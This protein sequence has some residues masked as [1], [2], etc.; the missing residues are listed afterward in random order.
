ML[1]FTAQRVSEVV[2]ARWDEVDL[3]TATW[4]I[5]RMR[6][7]KKDAARG[8]HVVPLP[9]RLAAL[10]KQWRGEDDGAGNFVCPA[11][12]DPAKSITAE[13]C[14]KHYRDVLGLAGKHSPHSWRSS[15]STVC[16]EAGKN[17]DVIE[18]QLDHQVGNKTESAYD[19]ATRLDL[20]C[21][22]MTWYESALVAARDG[23][24]VVPLPSRRRRD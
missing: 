22:L 6:M 15:F 23:A 8:P 2:G 7:K 21:E 11:P 20:R 13:A 17:R 5:P 16:R 1:A 12:R 10:L 4:T 24:Q 18:A 9:P 3:E 19:R 14:E